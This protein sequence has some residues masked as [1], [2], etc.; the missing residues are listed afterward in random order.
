MRSTCC[1]EHFLGIMSVY[2]FLIAAPDAKDVCCRLAMVCQEWK[3]GESLVYAQLLEMLAALQGHEEHND[4]KVQIEALEK[5][6]TPCSTIKKRHF[7]P[8]TSLP[9][10][11]VHPPLECGEIRR[12]PCSK[13]LPPST[14]GRK[15]TLESS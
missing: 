3:E 6:S 9:A 12:L 4:F 1:F 15:R 11:C 10:V 7:H 13:M 5:D 8:V 14:S 2:Q